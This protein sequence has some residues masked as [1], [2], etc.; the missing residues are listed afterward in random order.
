MSVS[1]RLRRPIPDDPEELA[2]DV[3]F[4]SDYLVNVDCPDVGMKSESENRLRTEIEL[5]AEA[6]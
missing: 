5:L 1:Q 4:F 2:E 3:G 6:I